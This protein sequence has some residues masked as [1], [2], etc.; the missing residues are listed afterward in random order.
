MKKK[1]KIII[2]ALTLAISVAVTAIS[3]F[4]YTY[5]RS[6]GVVTPTTYEVTITPRTIN[7]EYVYTTNFRQ[8]SQRNQLLMFFE[9]LRPNPGSTDG[10]YVSYSIGYY[11]PFEYTQNAMTMANFVYDEQTGE[12]TSSFDFEVFADNIDDLP[13]PVD[14]RQIS[15]RITCRNLTDETWL[16]YAAERGEP[17]TIRVSEYPTPNGFNDIA[18]YISGIKDDEIALKFAR[19]EELVAENT[20][21]LVQ[22][23]RLR[24]QLDNTN[25][26][27]S[28]TN[29][30]TNGVTRFVTQI[31]NWSIAGVTLGGILTVAISAA[32]LFW[33]IK[34][35]R[36]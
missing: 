23:E 19:I 4:A 18:L 22:I 7:G 32:V 11:R 21:Q 28:L 29:G 2:L 33:L 24:T 9:I 12:T 30:L 31:G 10:Y 15:H 14:A 25:A 27:Y 16:S 3:S 26:L 8:S 5:D 35:A 36:A 34:S 13:T 1:T 6:N 17:V 20:E